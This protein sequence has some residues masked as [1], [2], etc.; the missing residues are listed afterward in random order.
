MDGWPRPGCHRITFAPVNYAGR[1]FPIAQCN[2]SYIFPAIGLAVVASRP[3]S[4][5]IGAQ[6][7][8]DGMIIA[9]PAPSLNILRA[10]GVLGVT[11]PPFE[12]HS[13]CRH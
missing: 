11:S 10:Q 8:T 6:R 4:G 12:E 5:L 3:P 1:T 9:L 2:N 13:Q 7:I